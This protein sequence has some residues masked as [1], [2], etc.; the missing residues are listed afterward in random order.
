ATVQNSTRVYKYDGSWTSGSTGL[1]TTSLRMLGLVALDS[2]TLYVGTSEDG[3]FKSVDGGLTWSAVN[4]NLPQYI[5]TAGMQ[6]REMAQLA[7]DGTTVYAGT[8]FGTEFFNQSFQTSG[9]G[10]VRTT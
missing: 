1:P 7:A 5:G 6:Y 3:I 2:S 8:G 9:G 4:T 10:V